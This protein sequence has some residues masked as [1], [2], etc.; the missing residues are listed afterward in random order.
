MSVQKDIT[1]PFN[2]LFLSAPGGISF[3]FVS[4]TLPY[5]LTQHGFSVGQA[6]GITAIGLSANLW[7]FLWAP[8]VDLTLSLNK[9]YLIG[10]SLCALS[11]MAIG[12]V[13][14]DAGY[15]TLLIIMVFISQVAATFSVAPVGG[16]M[17]KVV[18]E[19]Q[20]GRTAGFY[21]AGN[22]GG[23]GIG[24]GAGIWLTTHFSYLIS[25]IVIAVAMLFCALALR[26]IPTVVSEKGAVKERVKS[27]LFDVRELLKSKIAIY[28]ALLIM[29]PIGI[30]ALGS[31][32][33]SIAANWSVL[34]D[35]IAL[36]TG[37]LSA[38]ASIL[39]C[40]VGGWWCDKMNQWWGFFGAGFIMLVITLI[41][42]VVPFTPLFYIAG[43]LFYAFATGLAFAAF[44][45]VV[46]HAIGKGA[47]STKYALFSSLGNV[48]PVYMLAVDGW[49]YDLKGVKVTLLMEALFGLIFI[50][51]FVFILWRL[52]F[53]KE[54]HKTPID[55]IV[56][57]PEIEKILVA[58]EKHLRNDID[59]DG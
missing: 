42:A 29:T 51:L 13:P 48:A 44:S 11:L 56:T 55:E 31:M 14:L 19:S 50:L 16:M 52:K 10:V 40:T 30:G 35:T 54:D 2:F 49:I 32:W 38:I 6:A 36:V 45:A 17:A 47:A 57:A 33:S 39:G 1:S 5:I 41:L 59:G 46:L 18:D 34:P 7:R 9:W 23:I 15:K 12:M 43:V 8:I 3:G 58:P 21:Q 26:N 24:G 27:I 4:V 28:S 22:L 20:K 53:S 37:V 25:L